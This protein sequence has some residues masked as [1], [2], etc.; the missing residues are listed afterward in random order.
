LQGL[1]DLPIKSANG[2]MVFIRDVAQVRD[3]YPPQTNIVRVDGQRAA[4]LTILKTG[5]AS[6]LD[7]IARVRRQV[8]LTAAGLPPELK[9]LPLGDQSIFVRAS[10][11]GVVREA[12]IAACLT[13]LM[14]LL[15]LGSWRSTVIIAVSIP[16]S[17]L[18]SLIV[19]SALGETI[20]IM[21]LGGLALAVGILVDDATVAIENINR[22]LEEG[23]DLEPAIIEGAAQ[24]AIPAFV[25]TLAICIVFVP[26]F[27]LTG[28]SR[29]LFVRSP[30]RSS[31]RCSPRTSCRARSSRR[32]R[33][34]SCTRTRTPGAFRGRRPATAWRAS[35][36]PSRSAS[37]RSARGTATSSPP[38]CAAGDSSPSSS[39]APASPRSCSSSRGSARTSSPRSTAAR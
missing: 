18:T 34:R 3:G 1:N 12:I 17:I 36:V 19:L 14:I 8:A 35:S 21:T 30:K 24:I 32:W 10:I 13:G 7:I 22:Y 4:L 16:L 29:Y 33:R 20:N 23:R 25:S 37:R 27:F 26:M 5:A 31:S 38:A 15:F 9:V 2:A 39:S 11:N 28:V 6:T